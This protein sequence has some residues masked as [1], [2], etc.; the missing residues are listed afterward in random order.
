MSSVSANDQENGEMPGSAMNAE[1]RMKWV[2]RILVI[3][4]VL[5]LVVWELALRGR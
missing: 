1:N 4:T 5:L 3:I 2:A